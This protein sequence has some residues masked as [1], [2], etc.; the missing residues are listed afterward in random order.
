MKLF[1]MV[2]EVGQYAID[3]GCSKDMFGNMQACP[4]TVGSKKKNGIHGKMTTTAIYPSLLWLE[5]ESVQATFQVL[6]F[7]I[8]PIHSY[9]CLIIL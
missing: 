3:R 5:G 2:S 8:F 9:F 1:D 7:V 4:V 6:Y